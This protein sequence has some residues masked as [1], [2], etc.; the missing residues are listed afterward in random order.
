MYLTLVWQF[1]RHTCNIL[2]LGNLPSV[3]PILTFLCL[4]MYFGLYG[5][6]Q[7][8]TLTSLLNLQEVELTLMWEKRWGCWIIPIS[9]LSA[10]CHLQRLSA[11]PKKKRICTLQHVCSFQQ[12]CC[13]KRFPKKHELIYLGGGWGKN[14]ILLRLGEELL[15]W[16]RKRKNVGKVFTE[17]LLFFPSLPSASYPEKAIVKWHECK[18]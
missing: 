9:A 17:T 14:N 5:G 8:L 2:C 15:L 11:K 3:Y 18:N 1:S 6:K 16:P 13:T 4:G 12:A 10:R 7:H